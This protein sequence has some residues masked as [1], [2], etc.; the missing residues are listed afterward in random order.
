MLQLISNK[1]VFKDTVIRSFSRVKVD[2]DLMKNGIFTLKNDFSE[3]IRYFDEERQRM[4][5]ELELL[6]T[7]VKELEEEKRVQNSL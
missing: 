2:M 4:T 3:W 7:R 6:K 5:S 1:M